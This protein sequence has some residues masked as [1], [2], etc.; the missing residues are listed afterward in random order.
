MSEL[1]P[2]LKALL[3]AKRAEAK[4]DCAAN[5]AAVLGHPDLAIKLT[6]PPLEYGK[7]EQW[8]GYI[9]PLLFGEQLNNSAR[10]KA[11]VE[12]VTEALIRNEP[13]SEEGMRA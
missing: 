10:R 13:I 5:R 11:L 1:P 6:Q 7:P 4:S 3:H 12:L 2:Q 9:P 8:N